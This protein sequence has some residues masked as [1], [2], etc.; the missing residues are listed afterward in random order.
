MSKDGEQSELIPLSVLLKKDSRNR[1]AI[2]KLIDV[3]KKM[4][5]K[6]TGTGKASL[7][8]RVDREN[9]A[10]LFG[11][12]PKSKQKEPAANDFGSPKGFQSQTC[13]IPDAMKPFVEMISVVE[14]AIRL[15]KSSSSPISL[16]ESKADG[17]KKEIEQEENRNQEEIDEE[18]NAKKG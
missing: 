2:G 9:F 10:N 11:A 1:E 17:Q 3:A 16:N 14:P 6:V 4:G 8:L 18:K 5:I 13:S 15:K 12:A 7:S